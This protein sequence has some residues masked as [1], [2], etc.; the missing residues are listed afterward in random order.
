MKYLLLAA[1]FLISLISFGQNK[2]F[3][4]KLGEEYELPRKTEDLAFFGNDKDGI[5]NLSLKKEELIIVRFNPKTLAKTMEQVVNLDVTRNFNSELV[6]D[7]NNNNYYWLHSD[8]DKKAEMEILYYDKID[9]VKGKI[10][11]ANHKMFETTKIAGQATRSGILYSYK[12]TE[13]Y[14][15]N[16]D[17]DRKKLL[18]S[19]R[20][21]PEFRND[22]K[23][24]DKIGFQ[25]F[26]EN[27]N[28]VWG[29]EFK[30]PYTEAIMDNTDFSVDSKG[31]AYM[32][33]KVYDSDARKEKD[34][35]T[36]KPA[37]HYE[38]FK[39]SKDSKN[40]AIT[41]I[42]VEDNYI[43]EATLIENSVHEMIVACTFS[44]KSNS[45]GTDGIFL[46]TIDPDGKVIKYKNG[47][48]EFPKAEL[49]KFESARSR[50][51]MEKKDDY[52]S[53][54][55]K[56]RQVL[57]QPDGSIFIACEQFHWEDH[58]YYVNGQ[59][60]TVI[61]YYYDDILGSKISASGEYEWLRKIPKRQKGERGV[62]TMGYKLISDASGFYFLYLDNMKNMNIREE[63][64]PKYHIDGYG[65]QVVVSKIDN[66]GMLSKELLFDT[67]EEE[68]MIFPT[69]FSRINGNQ[70]I[71]RAR[72]KKKLFQPLLITSN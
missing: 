11:D 9:A 39:F 53:P 27:L 68:I 57:V 69:E 54:N 18:V 55:L 6:A 59:W 1:V 56:V 29:S 65:G 52:E 37:Y 66:S 43:K 15:Y 13:K 5:V 41:P 34:K 3:S 32:L 60:N 46:A 21:T 19:Y 47:Y 72:I 64:E 67:R 40:I 26:D 31:N 12:T 20:L 51:K 30:M 48:Y 25:V 23:N 71:G 33:V 17:A 28:K 8:W 7:F 63:E 24:Y 36:G 58:S 45:N 44:K 22:K 49:E 61:V 14:Q 35:N 42:A 4:F 38:V 10:A 70:F 2:K 16:Y 62:G 50:R